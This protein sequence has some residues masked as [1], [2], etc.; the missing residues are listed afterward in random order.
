MT[1]NM[2]ISDILWVYLNFM[3]KPE[4][5]KGSPEVENCS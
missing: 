5:K 3:K 4:Y 2:C 1:F